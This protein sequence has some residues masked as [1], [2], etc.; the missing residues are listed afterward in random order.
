MQIYTAVH[1]LDIL[2]RSKIPGE[3]RSFSCETVCFDGGPATGLRT[4]SSCPPPA[5]KQW[6]QTAA[7][8]KLPKQQRQQQQGLL[9]DEARASVQY[10]FSILDIYIHTYLAT[11]EDGAQESKV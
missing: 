10:I 5:N 4:I 2:E 6:K 11:E 1:L 3:T 7:Q 8:Q 9:A